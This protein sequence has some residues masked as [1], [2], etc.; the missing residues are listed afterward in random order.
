METV[1]TE[2]T[3]TMTFGVAYDRGTPDNPVTN[4]TLSDSIKDI[5]DMV[6]DAAKAKLKEQEE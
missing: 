1:E 5:C 4:F 3:V 2:V 6:Y